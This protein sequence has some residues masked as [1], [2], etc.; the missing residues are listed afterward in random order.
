MFG[1]KLQDNKALLFIITSKFI[2][3]YFYFF[4]A[5]SLMIIFPFI[6]ILLILVLGFAM[7]FLVPFSRRGFR[8]Q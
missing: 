8:K 2:E 3:S 6:L 5:I 1:K 4:P 7:V